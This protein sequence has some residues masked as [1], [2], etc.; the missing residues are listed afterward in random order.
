MRRKLTLPRLPALPEMQKLYESRLNKGI[1]SSIDAADIDNAALTVALNARCRYDAT[2]RRPGTTLLT[3]TK[4]NSNKVLELMVFKANDGTGRFFRFTR[5]SVHERGAGSWTNYT[6][7]T[8]G[9]LTGSDSDRFQTAVVFSKP[10]FANG[11]DKI[12][13]LDTSTNQYKEAG[14]NSPK[15]RFIT[16]FYNRVV[17]AY[18][19]EGSEANGAVTIVWSADG[20]PT[21]WPNDVGPDISS[22]QIPLIESPSDLADFITGVFGFSNALLVAREKSIWVGTKLPVASNPF[23]LYTAVP[24]VG[25]DCPQSI[26]VI[27]GGIA[28]VDTLSSTVW[29]YSLGGSLERIGESVEKELIAAIGDPKQVSSSFDGIAGE[30]TVKIELA[31]TTISRLWTYNVRTKAWVYDERDAI[32]LVSDIDTPFADT[33]TFDSLGGTFD[34]LTGTFDGLVSVAPPGRPARYYGFNNGDIQVEVASATD[35]AGTAF[36]M[37]LQSKEF[38]TSETD[39][40]FA[41]IHVVYLA[42]QVGT[43]NLY[44]TKDGGLTWKLA[45]TITTVINKR[46]HL[47]YIR[48]IKASRLRWRLTAPNGQL[49]II[50]YEIHAYPSGSTRS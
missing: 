36:T 1:I 20:D 29:A 21:K 3:P 49:S 45:K 13:Y 6:A 9:A 28:F 22:G 24:G 44:Y 47:R 31:G 37:D 34:Q 17:G 25:S 18:R 32:S 4:P 27:P 46:A 19:V 2:L 15:V 5:N 38:I 16:G 12:Q 48:Q 10:Y 35:D 14:A 40:Y 30:L 8:G 50:E 33:L 41:E 23:N 43:L 42:T 39:L 26:V 11:V 7:G